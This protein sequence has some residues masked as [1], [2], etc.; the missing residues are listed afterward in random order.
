MDSSLKV[1]HVPQEDVPGPLEVTIRSELALGTCEGFVASQ[2]V[3]D[4]A[5]L[6]AGF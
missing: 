3:M 5:T 2:A 1:A 6:P 4:V